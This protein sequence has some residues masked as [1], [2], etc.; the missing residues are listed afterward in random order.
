MCHWL[1]EKSTLITSNGFTALA[2]SNVA[3]GVRA[4]QPSA[5]MMEPRTAGSTHD[6]QDGGLDSLHIRLKLI[7]AQLL[8]HTLRIR[9]KLI[10]AQLLTHRHLVPGG[11]I[12]GCPRGS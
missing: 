3:S 7:G 6:A 1:A 4:S 12:G 8:T 5:V 2:C 11:P 9:L 10:G